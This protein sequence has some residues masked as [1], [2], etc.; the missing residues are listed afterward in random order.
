MKLRTRIGFLLFSLLLSIVTLNPA[1][2]SAAGLL[3]GLFGNL[4]GLIGGNKLDSTPGT[5]SSE[6]YLVSDGVARRYLL[7]RPTVAIE[8]APV[9]ILLHASGVKPEVMANLTRAGRLAAQY[10]TWV[11]LPEGEL[12]A[13]NENPKALF[14]GADDVAFIRRLID[15]SIVGSKLDN[16]RIFIAGYSNSGFMAER[17]ACELSSRI[18]GVA[19]VSA[20]LREV[21][22]NSCRPV[23]PMPVIQFHGTG[24]LI[25]PYRGNASLESAADG[26]TF[27]ATRAACPASGII[28]SKL[29]D[30]AEDGTT[31]SL[32]RHTGC[33]P[34]SEVRL[35]TVNGGGHTWPGS[36]YGLAT[37]ELGRTTQDIDATI[38]IWK[39]F[40]AY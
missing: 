20:S 3:G 5:S 32:R 14:G 7:I 1:P 31:V 36:G 21:Y 34:G 13:W 25:V 24:D 29:P 4:L 40:T 10:G 16:K 27:W 30:V 26:S 12:G 9:L 22:A 6:N 2:A 17:A 23:H 35:Y 39:F 11:Y 19:T 8:G 28:D 15:T 38:E 37:I 33:L 18:A